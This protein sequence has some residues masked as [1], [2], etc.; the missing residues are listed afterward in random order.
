MKG[1]E[2]DRTLGMTGEGEGAIHDGS[3]ASHLGK[4]DIYSEQQLRL[5]LAISW[6]VSNYLAPCAEL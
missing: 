5:W 6:G 3:L 1:L 4:E 2:F